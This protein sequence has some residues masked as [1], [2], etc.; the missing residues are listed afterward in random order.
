MR[1]LLYNK[2][3][4]AYIPNFPK[5]KALLENED[6]RSAEVRKVGDNLYR[7]RLDQSNRILFCFGRY[8][9][10]TFILVLE[11]IKR[12]S[13]EKSRFLRRGVTVNEAKLP[14]APPEEPG[15]AAELAYL[16]PSRP[17]FNVLNKI[18]S[19]DDQQGEVF[20]QSPP[21]IVVGSAGSGKTVLTL[22]KMKE[23]AGSVLYVTRS[24]YLV[25]SSRE[26]YYGMNYQN[27][28]QEVSFLSFR[29]Y[30][31]SIRVPDTREMQFVDFA[32]WFSRH[33]IATG[34][35][36]P[37]QLF[38]EINGVIAGS[39][40]ER[41]CLSRSDYL[42]LGIR[43]SIYSRE[44]REKVHGLFEKYLAHLK[45]SGRHDA[46]V[47]SHDYRELVTPNWDFIVV[48]EVQDFTNVQLDLVMRSLKD[49]RRFIL[50]GDSN[51]IVH[52]NFFSWAGLRRYF[53]GLSGADASA[54][55][56]EV[57][58]TNYRNSECV[59][60]MAN[61]ILRLKHARFGSVDRESNYLVESHGDDAGLVAL[62]PNDPD[63]TGELDNK[64]RQST[65]FAVVVMHDD[66][67]AAA[68]RRFRT[69]LIFSI[70]EAK[71]L[72]YENVILYD[73][74]S[75]DEARFREIA[76][77]VSPEAVMHGDLKYARARDKS[78]KSLE[79]FKFHIN[80]LYV[81][82]TRA[83]ANVYLVESNPGQRLFELLG[84]EALGGRLDLD[85][86]RSSL[87][88]W[89][90]QASL[91]ERQGKTEQAAEI[92]SRILGIRETGWQPLTGDRLR[93]LSADVFGAGAK[94]RHRKKALQ[95]FEYALL[96]HDRARLSRLLLAD[97]RP[98]RRLEKSS[99]TLEQKH[100]M[101]YSVKRPNAVRALV[102]RYGVDYR[103]PFNFTPLMLA[104][105]FG[106]PGVAA[107]LVETG[108]DR[109]LVNS[110]G[111]NA[112]QIMLQQAALDPRYAKRAMPGLYRLLAPGDLTL[113]VDGKLLKLDSHKVEFL[114]CQLMIALFYTALANN[115]TWRHFGFRAG[116]IERLL[117]SV[118]LQALGRKVTRG[119]ISGVLARNEVQRDYAYNRRIF[120][121]TARGVYIL[122]P[123]MHI[124]IGEDWTPVYDLLDPTALF[125]MLGR[126]RT[127][128]AF[129]TDFLLDYAQRGHQHFIG[130]IE[131]L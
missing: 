107:M 3:D 18:I 21:F 119:Y 28:D 39:S 114:F 65:R 41:G 48:D 42:A 78:D 57:L 24:R 130:L 34:L 98:A 69:P 106:N 19:F 87:A 104:A 15:E 109:E 5:M 86:Q 118:A 11:Y 116:D 131:E 51:Q 80:A 95:L 50:C 93:E 81:A 16:H 127:P 6:Y 108:T 97:F 38:E 1:V 77:N 53:Y 13:Y 60:E 82:A 83:I 105:R 8:R 75:G 71:G 35:K 100:F 70:Q 72:E 10:D 89:Q 25:D 63:V 73:F 85:E 101:P 74:V 52:P 36:D 110:A 20:S 14:P 79:I 2:L 33:R 122:N 84:I 22:E 61:R 88:E 67:K 102:E 12:H 58:N 115:V 43:Q 103:D 26:L 30:L 94:V 56:A 55:L 99:K 32:R 111:L 128:D 120:R 40:P 47:L 112:F 59:T 68:R 49:R 37:Y 96:S 54:N 76:R 17:T 4:A 27:D 9:G 62:L 123:R 121:R 117:D 66:Q 44:E 113:M 7:A 46:N 129:D 90:R 124:R 125:D 29:E 31:E 126:V 92:R 23:A 91:L 45:E 64:T